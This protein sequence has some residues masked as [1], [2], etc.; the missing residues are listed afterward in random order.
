MDFEF[1]EKEK[2][3]IRDVAEFL[4]ANHDPEVMDLHRE[5]LAQLVDTPA[6]RAFMR[7]LTQRGSSREKKNR[8]Y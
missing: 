4:E 1:S 8:R 2:Q 6:R 7:K 3:F 5:N